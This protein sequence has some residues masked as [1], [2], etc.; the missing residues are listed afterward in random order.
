MHPVVHGVRLL[1][2]VGLQMTRQADSEADAGCVRLEDANTRA[3]YYLT[4]NVHENEQD[5]ELSSFDLKVTDGCRPGRSTVR[6][7]AGQE[8]ATW[9]PVPE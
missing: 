6:G 7:T 8:F 3:T 9:C 4:L 2:N 5:L 1:T